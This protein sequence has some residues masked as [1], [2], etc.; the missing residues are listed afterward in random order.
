MPMSHLWKSVSLASILFLAYLAPVAEGQY[1]IRVEDILYAPGPGNV[2]YSG[3]NGS[4]GS[5]PGISTDF[6]AFAGSVPI[7]SPLADD[8]EVQLKFSSTYNC[9]C[10]GAD[11]EW[12]SLYYNGI[13]N[14]GNWY[15]PNAG[16]CVDEDDSEIPESWIRARFRVITDP[17]AISEGPAYPIDS[18]QS[19]VGGY[20]PDWFYVSGEAS[21]RTSLLEAVA[22]TNP[23]QYMLYDYC[24]DLMRIEG[25]IGEVDGSDA[26]YWTYHIT[27]GTACPQ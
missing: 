14:K 2:H 23:I 18:E 11:Q 1:N 19:K 26:V 20:S 9:L 25:S 5:P 3:S 7:A 12:T 10:P 13:A 17:S 24:V 4:P 22:I 15:S 16:I 6:F 8:L 27:H 21:C